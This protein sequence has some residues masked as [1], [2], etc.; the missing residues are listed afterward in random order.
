LPSSTL[1]GTLPGSGQPV[2]I[3]GGI[4]PGNARAALAASGAWGV[5]VCSGVEVAPGV[6]NPEW[7]RELWMEVHHGEGATAP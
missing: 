6:K 5:D 2:W 4:G 3:A 1:P 7:M